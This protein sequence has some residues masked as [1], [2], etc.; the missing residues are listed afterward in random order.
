MIDHILASVKIGGNDFDMELP[1]KIKMHNLVPQIV[2][3]VKQ[4]KPECKI[5]ENAN[6]HIYYENNIIPETKT[7]EECYIWD[8]AALEIK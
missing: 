4:N 5:E 1:V 8:G 2:L 7:L 3:T 6:V